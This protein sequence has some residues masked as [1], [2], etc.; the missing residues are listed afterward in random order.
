M[1][2]NTIQRQVLVKVIKNLAHSTIPDIIEACK[3]EFPAISVGTIYRNLDSL[4]KDGLIRR[5]PTKFKEDVYESTCNPVHDHFI[6][7]HC[8]SISD[9]PRDEKFNEYTNKFGD[10]IQESSIMYYGICNEC[11]NKKC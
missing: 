3:K 10:L 2:R 6:C 11:L 1:E 4:E 5:I 7:T 8:L 9:L